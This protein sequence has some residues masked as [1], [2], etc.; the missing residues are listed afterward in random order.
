VYLYNCPPASSDTFVRGAI[1]LDSPNQLPSADPIILISPKEARYMPGDK[2]LHKFAHPPGATYLFGPD[3]SHF[4]ADLVG[5]LPISS[6]VFIPTDTNF[7]MY[8]HV[9]AAVTLYDRAVK[10]G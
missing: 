4:H 7:E 2:S 10:H 3:D 8:S 5:D 1:I 9:A 6:S